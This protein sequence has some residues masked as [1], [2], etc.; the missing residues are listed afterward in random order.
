MAFEQELLLAARILLGGFFTVSGLNHFRMDDQLSGWMESKGVPAAELLNYF[1]GGQLLF[2]GLAVMLGAYVTLG[3]GALAVFL[4]VTTPVMHDFW[5]AESQQEEMT[6][7][8]K[9]AA[10]LG[11]LLS[12]AALT[13]SVQAIE[14][15]VGTGLL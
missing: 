13:A 5:N 14:Y 1:V 2:G 9:N 15:A 4:L 6:Q 7:F 12:L 3:I 11:G 10:I 8:M